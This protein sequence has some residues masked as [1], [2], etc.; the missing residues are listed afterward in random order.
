MFKGNT[1]INNSENI[2]QKNMKNNSDFSLTQDKQTSIHN[3]D[4]QDVSI[5]NNN[6]ILQ[7]EKC[8]KIFKTKNGFQKHKN[9]CKAKEEN[10]ISQEDELTEDEIKKWIKPIEF[11][12]EENEIFALIFDH[13]IDEYHS[14]LKLLPSPLREERM[15]E[16]FMNY[17]KWRIDEMM[18]KR[19]ARLLKKLN[20]SAL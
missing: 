9:T 10:K 7:C 15:Y 20:Q 8:T 14:D 3:I 1:S 18:K 4:N 11:T 12:E 17:S 2:F 5:Q 6:H 19:K 13:I 16:V